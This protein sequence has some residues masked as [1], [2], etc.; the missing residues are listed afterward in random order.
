MRT[1]K[2]RWIILHV[3]IERRTWHKGLTWS[4]QFQVAPH[5][6]FRGWGQSPP[7]A[8][9]VAWRRMQEQL[10]APDLARICS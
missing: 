1:D 2:E 8:L 6:F 3:T 5:G 9:S 7:A 4:A 10:P